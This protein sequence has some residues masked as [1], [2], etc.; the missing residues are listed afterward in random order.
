[1]SAP[2]AGWVRALAPAKINPFLAV[3]GKRADGFH[4][5][6]TTLAAIGLCDVVGA[7]ASDAPGV[8]LSLSG[9]AASA[10]VPRDERNLVVRAARGA[11]ELAASLGRGALGVELSL[12]KHVPSQAGLGGGSSDA[13][14]AWLAC[15]TLFGCA[16]QDEPARRALAAL[17]S[18]C[19]F[20]W[21][22]RDT[23][24]ARCRGRGE[25]VEALPRPQRELW[26]VIA[27]PVQGAST[28]DVYRAFSRC[29]R[30]PDDVSRRRTE[31]LEL[32]EAAARAACFNGLERAALSAV[33][34]LA[35]W[36]RMLD[37]LACSHFRLAGSGSS[38]FGL[39][40][41][42]SAAV[43]TAERL[44]RECSQRSLASRG[45]R[46]VPFAGHGARIVP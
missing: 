43:A 36:R 2:T 24:Y 13:A 25:L 20:F 14:A 33:P 9:P 3:L 40:D 27:T 1:M 15:A 37:E 38:F 11:L 46:V 45:V 19:V 23:G 5:L 29:P 6:D 26:V 28:A 8:T 39:F 17:G 30:D 42:R 34:D 12:E 16:D 44:T 35:L 22:A 32:G 41:E 21:A 4:E 7:R 31:A 10:D 18:D